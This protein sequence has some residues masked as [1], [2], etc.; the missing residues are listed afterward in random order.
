MELGEEK[1]W[2]LW[3]RGGGELGAMGEGEG[4]RRAGSYG[5]GEE[6][7]WELWERGEGEL[8]DRE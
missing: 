2:E 6:E 4:R 3:E 7:G 1:S 5:R 8:G